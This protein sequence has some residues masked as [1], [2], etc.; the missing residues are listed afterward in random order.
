VTDPVWGKTG[1]WFY[2]ALRH[3]GPLQRWVM[4]RWFDTVRQKTSRQAY[5]PMTLSDDGKPVGRS[6]RT[7]R[8][9]CQVGT[10]WVQGNAGMGKSAMVLDLQS[11]FFADP[12]LPTLRQAFARFRSVPIIVPLREYRHVALD[13]GHPENWVPSVARM[14]VSAFGVAFE[15][16]ALFRAM[17]RSGGFLLVLDGANEVERD[18]VI[19]LF[20]LSAPAARVLVTSQMPGGK[21]LHELAAARHHP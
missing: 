7:A 9:R 13:S 4:A 15:D 20:T 14:A 21:K 16:D 10:L 11:R 17:V 12:N 19:E 2:F 8:R 18:E 5:L 1:L 3:A 6:D